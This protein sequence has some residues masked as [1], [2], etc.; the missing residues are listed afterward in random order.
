M[1]GAQQKKAGET[2]LAKRRARAVPPKIKIPVRKTQ[3][4]LVNENGQNTPKKRLAKW[5]HVHPTKGN[6]SAV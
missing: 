5:R 4:M 3:T 2:E 1:L 6:S